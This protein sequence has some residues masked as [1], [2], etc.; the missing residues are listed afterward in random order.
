MY[1][2]EIEKQS[3]VNE[4]PQVPRPLFDNVNTQSLNKINTCLFNYLTNV[5]F[6]CVAYP[7]ILC[8]LLQVY[9]TCKGVMLRSSISWRSTST[10]FTLA[11]QSEIYESKFADICSIECN[12]IRSF[13]V[14][15]QQQ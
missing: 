13:L 4:T 5:L 2:K 3:L 6:F 8:F 1:L 10:H 12:L 15:N 14:L 9:S 7:F 11:V